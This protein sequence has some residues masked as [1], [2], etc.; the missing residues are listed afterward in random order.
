[1]YKRMVWLAVGMAAWLSGCQVTPSLSPSPVLTQSGTFSLF[2]TKTPA[3]PSPGPSFTP[4]TPTPF[5]SPTVTPRTHVVKAGED[6]SG[7]ALRYRVSL[8][9]LQAANPGINPR[10]MPIGTVLI[11][12]PSTDAPTAAAQ[13]TPTPQLVSLDPPSCYPD[14]AGGIWCFAMAHNMGNNAIA[15]VTAAMRVIDTSG[16]QVAQQTAWLALDI[17][18]VGKGLP[19][20]AHFPAPLPSSY[21]IGVQLASFLPARSLDERY[22]VVSVVQPKISIEPDR[23]SADA[24]GSIRL[25]VEKSQANTVWVLLVA[26]RKDGSVVG[27]RRWESSRGLA[28]GQSLDFAMTVYSAGPAIDKAELFVEA[29]K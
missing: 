12:P 26:Y 6:M 27:V 17:L 25:A 5:P 7:I 4:L 10:L 23:M 2:Q 28:G 3:L 1:M 9:A 29:R 22:P 16:K 11:I 18:P 24:S 15:N 21:Q 14:H 20:M 13:S 8:A 19:V